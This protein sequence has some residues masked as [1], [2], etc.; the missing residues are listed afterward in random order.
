VRAGGRG[1]NALI[2]GAYSLV[3]LA[4]QLIVFFGVADETSSSV[5]WAPVCALVF[6]L[7]AWA[8]G[9]LTIRQGPRSA[10][11]G[12]LICFLPNLLFCC[13]VG[14]VGILHAFGQLT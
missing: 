12:A 3:V 14:G 5:W 8:A 6:P 13:G 9:L 2:Y 10:K 4:M 1:R 7:I 11:L